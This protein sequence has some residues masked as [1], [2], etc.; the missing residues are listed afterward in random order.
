MCFT[1][2]NNIRY[3]FLAN[4]CFKYIFTGCVIQCA[5]LNNY[6]FRRSTYFLLWFFF[7]SQRILYF[8]VKFFSFVSRITTYLLYISCELALLR[9]PNELLHCEGF[10]LVEFVMAQSCELL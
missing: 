7:L 6:T 1:A 4:F 2:I 3:L 8:I 9:K 10:L 5:L